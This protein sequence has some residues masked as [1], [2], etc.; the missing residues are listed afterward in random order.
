MRRVLGSRALAILAVSVLVGMA[1][2]WVG[3]YL[4]E[5]SAREAQQRLSLLWPEL[6]AMPQEDRAL[7][8]LL[9]LECRL[10]VQPEGRVATI[11]CLRSVTASH[12][13]KK[14]ASDPESQLEKLL[15][16][17]IPSAATGEQG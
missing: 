8:A 7:L 3:R 5:S 10:A 16:Q 6:M 2:V 13:M 4:G 14:V 17:A 12:R 9:A 11:A 15:D 1:A